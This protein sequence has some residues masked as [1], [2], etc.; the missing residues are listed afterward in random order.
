MDIITDYQSAENDMER[1]E[2]GWWSVDMVRDRW[3]QV[4]DVDRR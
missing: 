3:R 4:G 2:I 1:L